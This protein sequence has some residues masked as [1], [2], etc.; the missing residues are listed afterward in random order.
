MRVLITGSN[1]ALGSA[2]VRLAPTWADINAIDVEDCDLT[3]L[4]TLRARL[5]V[6]APD[7]IINAAAYSDLDSAEINVDLAR[8]INVHAV[9]TMVEALADTGGKMVQVSTALVFDG[10]MARPYLPG[11]DRNPLSVFGRTKAESEDEVRPQDLLIRTACVYGVGDE[12]WVM[13]MIRQMY[14]LG[15]VTAVADQFGAPTWASGL[16]RTIWVLVERNASGIYHHCDA[17]AASPHEFAAALAEDALEVG[18]IPRMPVVK[19]ISAADYLTLARRPDFSVLDCRATRSAL[20]DESVQWRANLR[21]ML[22][23]TARLG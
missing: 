19:P 3:D 10:K 17:G 12:N 9:T 16:A 23:E 1:G 21:S 8:A 22:Q 20:G 4:P 7:L 15:E 5:T 13:A 6:E 18:L 2:L 14:D 11:D